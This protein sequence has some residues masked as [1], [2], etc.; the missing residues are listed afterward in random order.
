MRWQSLLPP[1]LFPSLT[2]ESERKERQ[3]GL[4]KEGS[5]RPNPPLPP[6]AV[7]KPVYPV[8]ILKAPTEARLPGPATTT[9][10]L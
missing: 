10:F 4:E 9:L 2:A 7:V 1:Y 8:S 5:G 3:C 6:K